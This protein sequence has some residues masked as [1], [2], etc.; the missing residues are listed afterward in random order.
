MALTPIV[1]T[2]SYLLVT[3]TPVAVG[4]I[5]FTLTGDM[6]DAVTKKTVTPSTVV[7]PLVNGAF[8]TTLYA[9]DDAT[10]VPAGV[11]Y[12]VVE[13][14]AGNSSPRTYLVVLPAA[15]AGGTV[16]LSALAPAVAASPVFN[17]VTVAAAN[18]AYAL[19]VPDWVT[20]RAYPVGELVTS[21]GTLYRTTTAHTSAASFDATKFTA[22]GE[23]GRAHV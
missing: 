14:V 9:N 6:Q 4:Q 7:A 21:A 17:Y 2:G 16:D 12:Q 1:V 11:A 23:I 3:G 22:I 19:R 8:S 13:R 18:A 10:T 5:E 15:S 20:A